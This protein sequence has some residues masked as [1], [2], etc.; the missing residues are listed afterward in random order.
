M[1]QMSD[2]AVPGVGREAL[3]PYLRNNIPFLL[4]L[5]LLILVPGPVAY[6]GPT[7]YSGIGDLQWLGIAWGVALILVFIAD[8][9]F[10][11]GKQNL[12]TGFRHPGHIAHSLIT[13]PR[14]P[15][16]LVLL[17]IVPPLLSYYGPVA[18]LSSPDWLW[19][20]LGW[21]VAAGSAFLMYTAIRSEEAKL[22]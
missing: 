12:S 1:S 5:A 21:V 2:S 17:M 4:T 18:F 9:N 16:G 10:V 14:F 19:L 6:F 3:T 22:S 20:L 11:P 7:V 15:L 13:N 8:E